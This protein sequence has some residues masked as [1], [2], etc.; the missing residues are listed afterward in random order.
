MLKIIYTRNRIGQFLEGLGILRKIAFEL[1]LKDGRLIVDTNNVKNIAILNKI[2]FESTGI[3]EL[4]KPN[5]KPEFKMPENENERHVMLLVLAMR[6]LRP[7]KIAA[8]CKDLFD[9]ISPELRKEVVGSY[10]PVDAASALLKTSEAYCGIGDFE[11]TGENMAGVVGTVRKVLEK[12]EVD[13]RKPQEFDETATPEQLLGLP[14]DIPMLD[15]EDADFKDKFG[16]EMWSQHSSSDYRNDRERPYNGQMH[17]DEGLR[18]KQEVRGLTM[19]DI[20]DCF[21]KGLLEASVSDKYLEADTFLKCWDYSTE[22]ATPTPFLLEHQDEPDFVSTKVSTG[23]WRT[24]DVYKVNLEKIDPLAV[25]INMT[26]HIEKMMGIFP[27]VEPLQ[28]K[29]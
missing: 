15:I 8:L 20:S 2:R 18:G 12:Y 14:A 10:L 6:G 24:Q 17:T 21:I 5:I 28:D 4:P 29:Q 9:R 19:R 25:A 11:G 22:P 16:F 26:N 3:D 7:E 27:N 1:E 23:T 13:W